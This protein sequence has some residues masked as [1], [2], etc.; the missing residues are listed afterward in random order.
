MPQVFHHMMLRHFSPDESDAALR[1]RP[2]AINAVIAGNL[3]LDD[4]FLISAFLATLTLV[5]ALEQARGSTRQVGSCERLTCCRWRA[6]TITQ[7]HVGEASR[8][9]LCCGWLPW[10]EVEAA[11]LSTSQNAMAMAIFP[12][13]PRD[14]AVKV[15]Q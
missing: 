12:C 7:C 3:G 11:P 10:V 8:M 13:V 6:C 4:L 15:K 2:V 14:D 9:D 1:A 5:P